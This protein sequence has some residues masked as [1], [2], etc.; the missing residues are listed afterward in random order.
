MKVSQQK[1]CKQIKRKKNHRNH[2]H[3]IDMKRM[4]KHTLNF[5]IKLSLFNDKYY[6]GQLKKQCETNDITEDKAKFK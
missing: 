6:L 3:T 5:C 1:V 2:N 4:K